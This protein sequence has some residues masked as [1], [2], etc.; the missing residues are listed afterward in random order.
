MDFTVCF[1]GFCPE[2]NQWLWQ[3]LAMIRPTFAIGFFF[4]CWGCVNVV[5]G[6]VVLLFL[7]FVSCILEHLLQWGVGRTCFGSLKVVLPVFVSC[8]LQHLLQWEEEVGIA[9]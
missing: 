1:T 5:F 2:T 8:L 3:M 4:T 9:L 6:V 7:V